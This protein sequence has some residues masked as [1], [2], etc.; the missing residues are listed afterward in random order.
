MFSLRTI[1]ENGLALIQVCTY[2]SGYGIAF[3]LRLGCDTTMSK[4]QK[5]RCDHRSVHSGRTVCFRISFSGMRRAI[6][7]VLS[8][9]T[10]IEVRM[11]QKVCK[12]VELR[13]HQ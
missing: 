6:M 4:E 11:R 12:L 5:R 3:L 13:S 2:T 8:C 1:W 9:G 7:Q 10:V